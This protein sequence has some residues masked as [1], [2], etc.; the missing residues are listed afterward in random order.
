M[1]SP[2]SLHGA[3]LVLALGFFTRVDAQVQL[4][5]AAQGT[6][7]SIIV[8]GLAGEGDRDP[9]FQA[10]WLGADGRDTRFRFQTAGTPSGSTTLDE[11]IIAGV[12]QYLDQRV[13]FT[14]TGVQADM[15]QA[16]LCAG[17]DRMIGAAAAR[18]GAPAITLSQPTREQLGRILKIDW[19]RA[20]FGADGG[21]DQEKYLAIYYYV[22]AQRQEL[23]RQLRNDLHELSAI[24]V[25]QNVQASNVD[26]GRT[27]PVPTVCTTVF[28]DENFLCALDLR[29]D[30]AG[31]PQDVKLTDAM[32]DDIAT[33]AEQ[34]EA[35][36]PMPK[37]RKR[38][39]WL[40]AELDAINAK[41]DKVDQ[42]KE[43]W[44]LRDR[45]DD[46][47][48]R[49]TDLG[50]QVDELKAHRSQATTSGNPV[51]ALSTLTGKNVVV[52][53]DKGS[54]ALSGDGGKLLDEVVRAMREAPE[55]R[56]LVTGYA[57]RSGDAAFN[58]ALSE[59]RAKAV[60]SYLLDHGIGAERVLLNYYGASR[61]T[62]EDAA[63][64]RVELEWTR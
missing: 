8:A 12:E 6:L 11:L 58:L 51:A 19:S 61:S 28:D 52:R 4:V 17:I 1:A 38:D 59:R 48:D 60:R 29:V 40:K 34:S 26:P 54:A 18:F 36:G 25:L 62:G 64:R 35:T 22:R 9:E 56:V 41:I 5:L 45:M 33:K 42:R 63:E 37:L 49:V 39:R 50:L 32:L 44:A 16:L 7:D 47:E 27:D 53:F 3:V 43:L 46:L 23:E 55:S 2:F 10:A 15:P 30:S 21:D 31:Q 57:D 14:R 24:P 13:H 20:T